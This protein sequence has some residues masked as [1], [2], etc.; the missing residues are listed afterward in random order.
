MDKLS[1]PL[2]RTED[3]VIEELL[4]EVLVY[5]LRNNKAHCLNSSA[6]SVWRLCDGTRTVPEIAEQLSKDRNEAF[7]E[8]QVQL[9]LEL[10]R[11]RRLLE[12]SDMMPSIGGS[13]SRRQM[14]RTLG[15]TAAIAVPIITSIVA[16]TPAHAQSG[17]IAQNQFCTPGGTPCCP[18]TT[19]QFV[20]PFG[21]ICTP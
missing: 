17:C 7:G 10:L 19:C 6:A 11:R 1:C 9:G 18:G 12:G 15:L 8:G 21:N 20:A 2:A 16:P 3:L 5:D 13:M 14:V 4:H